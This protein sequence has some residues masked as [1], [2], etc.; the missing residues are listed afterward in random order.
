MNTK[1]IFFIML[2]LTGSAF[3]AQTIFGKWKTINEETGKPNSIIE[4]YEEDGVVNGKV[5]RILKESDRDRLCFNCAG[6]LKD[7]P[8]EGLELMR[9]L[10][11]SGSEYAGGV[12]TDPKTGKEYKV[13]V[14]VDEHNPNRLKVRGYIAFFY[15]TETWHRTK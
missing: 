15:R 14:W 2:F 4:I 6:D 9:G 11:K 13:K 8:I 7:Q 5:V 10:E 3:Q 12:I 1:N